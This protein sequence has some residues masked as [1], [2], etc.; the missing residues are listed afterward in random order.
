MDPSNAPSTDDDLNP[1]QQ[2]VLDQLGASADQRPEFAD[3]LRHHLRSAIETAVEPHLD[4]LPA[5]ED[6]FVH[7]HRLAQVHGC[8]AKFLADEAEEFE[9]RVPTARGTIVH[10]AVELAVNWRR[11]VEPPTLID[12]ALARY[13]TDSGSLGHWLRGCGEANRAELRSEALDAFTKYLECWPP[14]KPAWRPVTES[15]LR[16]ELCDGRLIL[17]GKVDLTLGSARGQQ[18]GKVIVDLKTGGSLPIHR[19]DLRFYALVETLRIGVPPRL[20]ASYYLDQ[21]HFVPEAVTED[22]LM[23]AVARLSDGVGR[24][25]G[26]LYGDRTPSRIPGPPCRWCPALD[27]CDEGKAHRAEFDDSD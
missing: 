11:E 15:R 8:E 1:A 24:L 23:A 14:L 2:A 21:A 17:A 5:G 6:L 16:A 10:K 7:K 27:T 9:W 4:S 18:A 19:E 25:V 12:E 13:E 3:D 20:L 26:L 22:T